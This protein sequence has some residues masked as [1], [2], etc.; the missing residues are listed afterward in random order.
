M[1]NTAIG[2]LFVLF[3][4]S[5]SLLIGEWRG[6][7]TSTSAN[8]EDTAHTPPNTSE[9]RVICTTEYA[10]VCGEDGNTYANRCIA[11]EQNDTAV[12]YEGRCGEQSDEPSTS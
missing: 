12:A 8:D 6:D 5:V 4:I 3:L 7:G 9:D 2:V 1:K 10:P 11:E